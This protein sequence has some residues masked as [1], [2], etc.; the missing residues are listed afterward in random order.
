MFGVKQLPA[1]VFSIIGFCLA[2]CSPLFAAGPSLPN[3]ILFVTQVHVPNEVNDATVSN[4]F[5]SVVSPL[6]NHLSDTAHAG[7]GGDLWIRYTDGTLRNLTRAAGYGVNGPQHGTGIAVRDPHV[8][9]DGTK[10]LFSMVVG[11]PTG[12]GQAQPY[13]WQLYEMGNF[14]D[15]AATPV[16]ARVPNQ[17]TNYN[18]TMPCYGSDG[19]ILF[20]C[21]R[22]RDGSAHLY[23]QLDE[24]NN[25]PSNTGLWS[26]DP[27]TG[28]LFLLDHSPSGVFHPFLD[29]F[30]R[31]LFTRWDHLVQDRNATDDRMGRATNRTFDYFSESS[32]SYNLT[33]RAIETFP[34]ARTYDSNQLAQTK[35]QG[36]ALNLFL[37]WMINEDGTAMEILNHVGRHE[38]A[39]NFRGS[40]FTNDPNLVQQYLL[41]AGSRFNTNFLNNFLGMREDPR[42][43]GSY[44]GIDGPDFGTHSAGQILSLFG[45]P[46]INGEQMWIK[47]Y[48][49]KTTSGPNPQGLYRNPLPM[50]D[51]TLVASYTA[52]VALDSNQGT[53]QF[54]RSRYS[55]RL[56]TLT[57]RNGIFTNAQLLTA[58]LTNVASYWDGNMLV[59]QTNA[60]WE[61]QPVEVVARPVPPR[62]TTPVAAIEAQ[63][64]ADEGVPIND[65]KTWLRTNNLALL[66]SRN[67]TAR[68]RA[69]REQPFNL[70]VPG[71]V[72]T[73]G[74]NSGKIYDIGYI[75]FLQADQLRGLTFGTTNPVPGRRVL[76]KP[77]HDPAA[78][79]FN[80]PS[81]NAPPGAS[82][83]GL[84]GSQATFVPARRALTH[85]TTETNGQHVVRERYW[86]TYQPGEIR[87][88]A[89]CHGLNVADQ[90]GQPVPTNSPAALRD[91]IRY[92]KQQTGYSKILSGFPSNG[93][94]RAKGS[95]APNRTNVLEA[96]TDLA[97]WTAVG[98]N[99][100]TTNGVFW[101]DDPDF[102]N[103]LRRFYRL[104]TF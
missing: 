54:P 84:D 93:V 7:R 69:D 26:L 9:W 39:Q 45:P 60:L 32:T 58:G 91:L 50:T 19:R 102:T 61:L 48:T 11:A 29:S 65:M 76:A 97:N 95:A 75:Q 17:P 28:D 87:T 89:V 10:A 72:Q 24:Y 78:V 99:G 100:G 63:V 5:V 49:P 1:I 6:G 20:A 82:R 30:G 3:P 16:I 22:P 23:P 80:V 43:P 38:L 37:P 88:C 35:V 90:A 59:T 81:S 56:T 74:T 25:V 86:I 68:D 4:V 14:L 44:L 15:P 92:W 12:P 21:D 55:F 94:F 103:H 33:N 62:Q 41:T 104:K 27:A 13:F 98:T 52:G 34:E 40:S 42:Q 31:V 96:T 66:V 77:M 36:N 46:G 2:L 57:N 73:L 64:F 51:G 18:N 83:L 85:Q 71:G 70:R 53:P 101:I 47:Y 79:A 8:H 67:V